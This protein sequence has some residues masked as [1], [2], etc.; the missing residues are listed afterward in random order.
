MAD[1]GLTPQ[2]P[3][4]KRLDVILNELHDSMTEKLGVNTRQNPQSLLNHLLT[5]IADRI[6]ELWELGL[7]VYYSQYPSTAENIDLDNAAQYG[8]STRETPV[9]SYYRILCTGTDGAVL[10][11]GT[12]IASDTNPA[13]QL[14]LREPKAITRT[15]F[16]TAA[17]K[18][19][20]FPAHGPLTAILNNVTYTFILKGTES[21]AGALAGLKEAI[22]DEAFIVDVDEEKE[23]L[24]IR[25]VDEV[26]SNIL[27]LSENLTTETIGSV[28]RFATVEDGDILLPN[29]IVTRIV[30]AAA[31]L[32]SVTN[33]GTYISGRLKETDIEFRKSYADKIFSR[34][35]RMLESIR[36]AIL[37]N[38]QGVT[39]VAPY[40][41]DSNVIGDM[42]RWPHSVEVVVD[43]GDNT[44]IA[45]Q[46]LN[47]KAGGINTYGAV[48]VMI[49]GEYGEDITVRFNRPTYVMV[50]FRVAITVSRKTALQVD[51]AER[52]KEVILT[53]M[54]EV[55]TG[56]DVMPQRFMV[57]QIYDRV[58]GVSYAD[59]SL[60]IAQDDSKPEE[61]PLRNVAVIARER[62]VTEEKQIEVVLNG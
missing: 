14:V 4:I 46:I 6:A 44:E 20:V 22:T 13:T 31:G 50:W 48:E 19:A 21:P 33:V 54:D 38:V 12:L 59:I 52:I 18:L 58:P 43:G 62:A 8:G 53:A 16:N 1:Y 24:N 29:G 39:S 36:S 55:D 42:G 56:Q 35:T 17:I 41:N 5:N 34:S 7:D 47:T 10:P 9:P 45:R 28:I 57:P 60:A 51:Y 40:E 23:L 30:K 25:A 27:V 61:Y 37:S 26:S 3:N 11:A 15:A 49:P 32:Q 2:G